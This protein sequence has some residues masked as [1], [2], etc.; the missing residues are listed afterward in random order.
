MNN[1]AWRRPTAAF[2]GPADPRPMTSRTYSTTPCTGHSPGF[3]SL[4]GRSPGDGLVETV[5]LSAACGG[6]RQLGNHV[7]SYLP[8]RDQPLHPQLG[9]LH[10]A[11]ELAGLSANNPNLPDTKECSTAAAFCMISAH[12]SAQH[13]PVRRCLGCAMKPWSAGGWYAEDPAL[14]GPAGGL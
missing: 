10:L 4:P 7:L 12:A 14:R 13:V 3:G 2:V 5:A 6:I 11:A 9:V 1:L 8:M